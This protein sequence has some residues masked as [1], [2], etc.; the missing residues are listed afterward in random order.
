MVLLFLKPESPKFTGP[1]SN[2]KTVALY[3]GVS[4]TFLFFKVI[5]SFSVNL[6]PGRAVKRK[7]GS[8]DFWWPPNSWK[9]GSIRIQRI[10]SKLIRI[11]KRKKS[12]NKSSIS[13]WRI[14][15]RFSTQKYFDLISIFKL[16]EIM[17]LI[18]QYKKHLIICQIRLNLNLF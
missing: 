12:S 14:I 15:S 7:S 3:F 4:W 5:T 17:S 1:I 16:C 8:T 10:R 6:V 11:T 2:E 13:L 9:I 18:R